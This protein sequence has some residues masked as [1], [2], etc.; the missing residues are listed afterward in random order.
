MKSPL[1]SSGDPLRGWSHP[2]RGAWIEIP[3]A[4]VLVRRYGRR[5]PHGVRGLK[6][7]GKH[8]VNM[9][10]LVAPHTGCVD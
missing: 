9:Y 5:T 1:E 4:V 6:S 7:P 8:G 10:D 2:T 3:P